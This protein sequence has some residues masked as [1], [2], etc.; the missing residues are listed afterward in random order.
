MIRRVYHTQEHR[1][2]KRIKGPIICKK[3]NAWLGEAFYFW[4]DE[5]DA[6]LWGKN[7]KQRTG[8][9]D[10][11][12]GEVDCENVLDTVFNE[13]QYNFWIKNIEKASEKIIKRTGV[14]PTLK[15]INDFFKDKGIWDDLDGILFQD[16]SKN[17]VHFLVEK[18]QYKK[19]IQ[20]ALYNIEKL[21]NFAHHYKGNCGN[22]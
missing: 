20:L 6:L 22:K 18:F 2:S 12:T 9:F 21:S 10:V 19:R 7:S 5:L 8:E 15:E 14:K 11:Y 1:G 3:D 17:Q 16:I 4:L 13:E